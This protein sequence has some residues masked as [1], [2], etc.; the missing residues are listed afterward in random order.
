[1]NDIR[2]ESGTDYAQA[3]GARLSQP[4]SPLYR[5]T[6]MRVEARATPLLAR[7]MLASDLAYVMSG[8]DIGVIPPDDSKALISCLLDLL[9]NPEQLVTVDG[10]DVVLQRE[11][12]V[13]DRVGRSIGSRLHTARNR[14]ES[15]RNLMPRLFFRQ[16]LW[17]ERQALHRLIAALHKKAGPVRRALAPLYHHLQHA[18]ATTLGEYLLSWA[19]NLEP[20]LTRLEQSDARIDVAPPSETSRRELME[21]QAAVTK[22]L[23]FSRMHSLRQQLHVTE[24]QFTDPFFSLVM[25]NVAL[26]RMAQDLRIWM[27]TEFNFFDLADEHAS[28]SSHLPQKKNP[29]GLQT[30]IGGAAVS[31]GRLAAQLAT[32][33]AP[34]EELDS[35]FNAGSL[36]Q[37]ALDIVGWTNFMAEVIERGTFHLDEMKAK[38]TIGYAGA[39]EALDQLVFEDNIP[40]R[41]AHRALGTF[42]RA[43]LAGE[44]LPSL[45][46]TLEEDGLDSSRIDDRQLAGVIRGETVPETALALPAV[47]AM[48]TAIGE[49]LPRYEAT[50]AGPGPVENALKSLSDEA[51]QRVRA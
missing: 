21:I 17:A 33:I 31:M 6:I 13:V 8:T 44:P 42:V 45:R 36:Y 3:V 10:G 49:R 19:A 46:K 29:F 16:V 18:S 24:D 32:S 11:A 39:S 22:R 15:I 26:S 2:S 7:Y 51:L 40:L 12:W 23:G 48:W 47:E 4:K 30:V 50:L 38:A 14:G 43:D 34:C 37:Q 35:V 25:V 27:T 1:M 5:E 20:Y 41:S 9:K 28:S